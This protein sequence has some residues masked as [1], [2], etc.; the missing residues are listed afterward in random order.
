MAWYICSILIF[1]LPHIAYAEATLYLKDGGKIDCESLWLDGDEVKIRI[2]NSSIMGFQKN[3]VDMKKTLKSNR[4]SE[5]VSTNKQIQST[6]G[7]TTQPETITDSRS[8]LSQIYPLKPK[9]FE[10]IYTDL[11]KKPDIS[12]KHSSADTIDTA[13]GKINKIDNNIEKLNTL[14]KYYVSEAKRKGYYV[15]ESNRIINH[16]KADYMTIIDYIDHGTNYI[17]M[18]GGLRGLLKEKY[19]HQYIIDAPKRRLK[20]EQDQLKK[21]EYKDCISGCSGYYKSAWSKCVE[22]CR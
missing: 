11:I 12:V 4:P 15:V 8:E 17:N 18:D 13:V 2:D 6:D 22:K 20:N 7:F 10:R 3:I 9:E 16:E 19:A 14:K 5:K 1:L 21:L